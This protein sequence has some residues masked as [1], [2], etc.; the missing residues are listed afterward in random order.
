MATGQFGSEPEWLTGTLAPNALGQS[1]F[2][3]DAPAPVWL[4]ALA[5]AGVVVWRLSR[6]AR[7]LFADRAADGGDRGVLGDAH[8]GGGAGLPA[9]LH[10]GPAHGDRRGGRVGAVAG[11][12]P[13]PRRPP[14]ADLGRAGGRGGDGRRAGGERTSREGTPHA[15]D[16]E[17]VDTLTAPLLE[18]YTGI[19]EPLVLDEL[20]NLAIP[21]YTRGVALQLERHGI[22]VE[23]DPHIGFM[24]A[25]SQVHHGG[26]ATAHV[27][28]ATNEDVESL[29][30]KRNVQLVARWLAVPLEEHQRLTAGLEDLEDQFEDG[31]ITQNQYNYGL[32]VIGGE[33][34]GD[35]PDTTANDV[36]LFV[37]EHGGADEG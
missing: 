21:W 14:G 33:M 11:A 37:D 4:L 17:V 31:E 7:R 29:L 16:V 30:G 15:D 8:G 36:A 35:W 26:P 28:V 27:L 32:T 3:L 19:D 23:V 22:P 5:A 18:R 2:V 24:F 20:T 12:R 13:P 34:A 25:R 6:E 9:G 10:V 1:P